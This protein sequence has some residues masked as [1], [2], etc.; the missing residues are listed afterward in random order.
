M[1]LVLCR[2]LKHCRRL[3]KVFVFFGVLVCL[4]GA[5]LWI[6]FAHELM[7]QKNQT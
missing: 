4:N 5:K 7:H 3:E 2:K 1:L 6:V